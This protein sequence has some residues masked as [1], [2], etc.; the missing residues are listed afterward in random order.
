MRYESALCQQIELI[1][2]RVRVHFQTRLTPAPGQCVLARVAETADPYLR[3]AF[4]PS[5]LGETGFAVDLARTDPALRHL[6]PGGLA[7]LLGPVGRGLPELPPRTRLLLIAE[8][9]PGPLLPL[10]A[11]AVDRAGTASLLLGRRYPLDAL[12]PELEVRIGDLIALAGEYAAGADLVYLN[13]GL[14]GGRALYQAL[15]K[16]RSVVSSEFARILVEQ[17]LPCGVG[18]CGACSLR[19][20]RGH[21]YAC[22][23]G[24]FFSLADLQN[25]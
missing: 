17:S 3:Q 4:F 20:A 12:Q 8:S 19:T 10:A 5:I 25:A 6:T 2:D 9:D 18:A 13:C 21:Q 15:V 7:D 22:Q 1:G 16:G 14:E 24:P 23:A 11:Q